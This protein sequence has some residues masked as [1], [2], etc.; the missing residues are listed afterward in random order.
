MPADDAL[1]RLL[2]LLDGSAEGTAGTSV[3]LP[4]NLRE[5]ATVAVD[6]G[7]ALSAA[8]LTVK[9][10]HDVLE[11]VAQRALLDQHYKRHPQDR[12][13]L[14]EVAQ[15]A[16]E[17]DGDPVAEEPALIQ[18]AA[19]LVEER[20]TPGLARPDTVVMIANLLRWSRSA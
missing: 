13:S 2:T 7:Y 3:R 4:A 16:A 5:A 17:L 19:A 18:E 9:G 12:P 10:L 6:M 15:A 20:E 1:G 8:E 14:A 11:A